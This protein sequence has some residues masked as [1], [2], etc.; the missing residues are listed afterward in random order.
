M[1]TARLRH[2]EAVRLDLDRLHTIFRKLGEDDGELAVC[3]SMEELANVLAEV[4]TTW[5]GGDTAGLP[6]RLGRVAEIGRALGMPMLA[7]VSIDA[8]SLCATYD[9]S[10]LAAVL[11]RLQRLGEAH[12]LAV[13][14]QQ[15]QTY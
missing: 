14:D 5:R 3:A 8:R 13:L 6:A 12:F 10:A 15:D 9:A 4:E 7:R 11:A 2:H 1:R